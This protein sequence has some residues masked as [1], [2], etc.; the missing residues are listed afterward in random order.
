MHVYG[1]RLVARRAGPPRSEHLDLGNHVGHTDW[2]A[3]HGVWRKLL[4]TGPV[5]PFG[6][7]F[8]RRRKCSAKEPCVLA[9]PHAKARPP[10]PPPEMITRSGLAQTVGREH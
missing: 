8:K 4:E 5:L 10:G 1:M 2:K 6:T 7:G 9:S 3:F